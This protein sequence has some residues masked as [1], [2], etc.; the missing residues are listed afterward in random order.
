MSQRVRLTMVTVTPVAA[1][2]SQSIIVKN[3]TFTWLNIFVLYS[4]VIDV[5]NRVPTFGIKLCQPL[6]PRLYHRC[7]VLA[8]NTTMSSQAGDETFGILVQKEWTFWL[9]FSL[10]KEDHEDEDLWFS[11]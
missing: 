2:L 11:D 4:V 6:R 1:S 7:S 10:M 5:L 9:L 8:G 3:R